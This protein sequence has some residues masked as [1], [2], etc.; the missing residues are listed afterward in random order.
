MSP[1]LQS[2]LHVLAWAV[3]VGVIVQA[4]LAGQ[5]WF[6]GAGLIGLHGGIGHGVFAVSI[7]TAALAWMHPA[8]R[9]AAY[10]AT[11]VVLALI[12]QIGLGYTGHRGG[13]G[14]AS[15]LHIPLGVL[16]TALSVAVATHLVVV[17]RHSDPA[18]R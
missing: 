10:L 18:R 11:L 5:S 3:P 15:A 14:E 8:R 7:A 17:A 6:A 9:P 4:M 1:K 13:V 16:V 12:A 2:I